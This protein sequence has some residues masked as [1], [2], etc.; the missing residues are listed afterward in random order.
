MSDKTCSACSSSNLKKGTVKNKFTDNFGG[1]IEFEIIE[2]TCEDCESTGDFFKENDELLAKKSQELNEKAVLSILEYFA[3]NH[4]SFASIERVLGLSQR[5]LTKWKNEVSA[6]T[7]AGIALMK[8]LKTFPWLLDVAD[9]KFEY[10]AAQKIH[11]EA[12]MKS[13]LSQTSLFKDT[14][15]NAGPIKDQHIDSFAMATSLLMQNNLAKNIISSL[16]ALPLASTANLANWAIP[17]KKE[18]YITN[19]PAKYLS[20]TV[21]G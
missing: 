4:V 21:Q 11:M 19:E 13:L 14:L 17:I 12:F 6:P 8:F 3:N 10:S 16:T 7:S 9:A 1:S 2:Y 18:E 5:T 15:K 20:L